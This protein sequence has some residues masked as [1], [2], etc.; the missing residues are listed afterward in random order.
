MNKVDNCRFP[1]QEHVGGDSKIPTVIYYDLLGKVRAVGA[2][3]LWER[4]D[5]IAE[6]ENWV[7]AE[8]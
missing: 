6:E 8:L 4:I 2:E 3:A 1:A 5:E 7:K